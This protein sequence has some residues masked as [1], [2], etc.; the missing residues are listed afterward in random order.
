MKR[1]ELEAKI[2]AITG[3]DV[4][5]RE[6]VNYV[7]T[8]NGKD[9]E[10]AKTT[11][12]TQLLE[13][14]DAKAA[15]ENALKEYQEGGQKFVDMAEFERLKKFETDT[16]T[17]QKTEKVSEAVK[18]LLTDNKA[19]DSL[20]ELLIKGIDFDSVK[21]KDDGTIEN[22]E[23]LIKPLKEKYPSCF[24]KIEN[25]T[26]A[27]AN[28][29]GGNGNGGSPAPQPKSLRDGLKAVFAQK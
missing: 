21:L 19:A 5:I 28:P 22:G 23:E 15:A 7:M 1:A 11:L 14:T 9:V 12:T 20:L 27:P 2:K 16:L 18:K 17:A 8:E 25:Q 6:L 26:G 10:S 4:D 13:A 3:E 29:P 24:T